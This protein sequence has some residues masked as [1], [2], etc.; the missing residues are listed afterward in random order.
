MQNM[1]LLSIMMRKDF[2]F[3]QIWKE[4]CVFLRVKDQMPN[5]KLCFHMHHAT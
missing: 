3:F 1:P 5:P 2:A 4:P